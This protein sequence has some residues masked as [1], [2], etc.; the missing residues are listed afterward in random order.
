M[1]GLVSRT[2]YV[3]IAIA[4]ISASF[5]GMHLSSPNLNGTIGPGA[6]KGVVPVKSS[7]PISRLG[8]YTMDM[9]PESARHAVTGL[10]FLIRR[11]A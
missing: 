4:Y 11:F 7:E 9:N 1:L 5:E 8:S 3:T 10:V 2:W 6:M